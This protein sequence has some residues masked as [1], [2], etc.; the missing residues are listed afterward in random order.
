M[1]SSTAS[2][3]DGKASPW[4]FDQRPGSGHYH[5]VSS[6]P[7]KPTQGFHPST[8]CT[9]RRRACGASHTPLSPYALEPVSGA[10]FRRCA[11][12]RPS[13]QNL[14]QHASRGGDPRALR[15]PTSAR[16]AT[17]GRR[18]RL[19]HP[20]AIPSTS[21]RLGDDLAHS[22]G[23][24][25]HS[26]ERISTGCPDST[27]SVSCSWL[28]VQASFPLLTLGECAATSP[29]LTIVHGAGRRSPICHTPQ[30]SLATTSRSL[31]PTRCLRGRHDGRWEVC[32]SRPFAAVGG[33]TPISIARRQASPLRVQPRLFRAAFPRRALDWRRV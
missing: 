33:G 27:A 19:R 7:E 13:G 24:R 26:T 25:P 17:E 10:R 6:T 15:F 20:F 4:I 16:A 28:L 23:S 30:A 22:S 5:P 12:H 29:V 32:L 14:F 8:F 31:L 3:R 11:R 21:D 9:V 18:G 2:S 1:V